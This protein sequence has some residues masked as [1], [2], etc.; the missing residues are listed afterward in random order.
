MITIE[1]KRNGETGTK[2][3]HTFALASTIAS[4]EQAGYEILNDGSTPV[5]APT[6]PRTAAVTGRVGRGVAVHVIVEGGLTDCGTGYRR[7][8]NREVN[9]TGEDVTCKLCR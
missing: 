3:V 5:A 7:G 2:R 4:F 9:V 8:T 1:F 6:A